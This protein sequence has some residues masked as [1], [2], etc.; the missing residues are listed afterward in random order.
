MD[1]SVYTRRLSELLASHDG[2]LILAALQKLRVST[3]SG[4]V[5]PLPRPDGQ[6]IGI[7][8]HDPDEE[9]QWV[10][11]AARADEWRFW[12]DAEHLPSST[13][14]RPV[15]VLGESVTRGY[16]FDPVTTWAGLLE[17]Y[18]HQIPGLSDV[19]VVD[20][21][22][23]G[24]GPGQLL[25]TLIDATQLRP[26]ALVL[27]AGNNWHNIDLAP[28]ELQQLACAL[29]AG[30]Y[31]A[32]RQVFHDKVSAGA[33]RILDT[34]AAVGDVLGAPVVV[35]V[36]EFN[37]AEWQDE[38]LL[39]CPVLPGSRQQDWLRVRA[40]AQA[41]LDDGD[42]Q[43]AATQA[44][45]MVHLDGG[46]S[47]VSQRLLAQAVASTG[48]EAAAARI[49]AKDAPVGL[50]A[51]HSPR[52]LTVVQE[53][54]R[55]KAAEHDLI[56][57]DVGQ[58]LVAVGGPELPGRRFFLDY[59]HLTADG[60]MATASATAAALAPTIGAE[61]VTA[62]QLMDAVPGPSTSEQARAHFLAAIHNAHYGQTG[63]T[64]RHHLGRALALDESIA[65]R[66]EDYL[67]YQTRTAPHWMC[68]SFERSAAMPELARYLEVSD[69]RLSGKLA[70]HDLRETAVALLDGNGGGLRPG[71][72]KRYLDLLTREHAHP[73]IDL[74][75]D[76][77]SA[78][79]FRERLGQDLDH[80]RA[81]LVARDLSSDFHAIAACPSV[82]TLT[83]TWRLAG[84]VPS[85]GSAGI[86][87]NGVPAGRVDLG[88]DWITTRVTLGQQLIR[89][90][91]NVIRLDW[92]LR[93]PPGDELLS[94]GAD[95]LERGALP[96]SMPA[97]G[98]VFAAVL[99]FEDGAAGG[100]GTD[101]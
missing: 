27:F 70:D 37:L 68:A 75:S 80:P 59:C 13:G 26:A 14:R 92:P 9:G 73:R 85:S 11:D 76:A 78:T 45:T 15:V 63:E 29:R 16:F 7:W 94:R 69:T 18:L 1:H 77:C 62:E 74:L 48:P 55:Q 52:P 60:L 20:L 56:C 93:C 91:R 83:I 100:R 10:R 79:T 86:S 95:C 40:A 66:I 2:T 81:F 22:S 58:V 67:D 25:R 24:A 6:T 32:V 97:F 34:I 4:S 84:G 54:M 51:P 89:C 49:A 36:P 5:P 19:D 101:E 28:D 41:A 12:A 42:L 43:A 47:A 71:T 21:A 46:T 30:A 90:G 17:E 64:V 99:S 31:P 39:T 61:Q 96:E 82:A 53:L 33:A 3:R 87:V 72:A 44:A 88:P 8:R 23:T 57:V 65:D 98:H 38:R 35:V 50:F